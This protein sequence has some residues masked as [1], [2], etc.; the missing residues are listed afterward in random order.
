MDNSNYEYSQS[1]DIYYR[2]YERADLIDPEMYK[3]I[4]SE[5]EMEGYVD[6]IPNVEWVFLDAYQSLISSSDGADIGY[7]KA[8]NRVLNE[9]M[10]VKNGIHSTDFEFEFKIV[11]GVHAFLKDD[12]KVSFKNTPEELTHEDMDFLEFF[13]IKSQ[14]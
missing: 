6:E 13:N 7:L 2:R 14:M 11:K 5:K 1:F 9:M 10:P 12:K 4:M 3:G 8:K